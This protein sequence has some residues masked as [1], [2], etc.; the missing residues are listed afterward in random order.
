M[1]NVKLVGAN[2]ESLDKL[3]K[4]VKEEFAIKKKI[5]GGGEAGPYEE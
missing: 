5:R 1:D 3:E 4:R 2:L